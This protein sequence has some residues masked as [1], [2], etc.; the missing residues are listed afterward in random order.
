MEQLLKGE[1]IVVS[2]DE[3]IVFDQL[4][5]NEDAIFSLLVAGGYLKVEQVEYR[6]ILLVP[7]YHLKITNLE[8]MSMFFNMFQGW[9][10]GSKYVY[11]GFVK[12]LLK[13]DVKEMNAYM[14]E[15][16]LATFSSFDTGSHPSGRTQPERFYHGFVL[17]LLVELRERYEVRSNRESG[18]GR[19]DVM[20]VPHD[21]HERAVILEFK[22]FDK[23]EESS[24]KDTV[25]AA[26]RQI[27][28]KR[29]EEELLLQGI[30]K[31]QIYKYGF[32]FEGKKVLIGA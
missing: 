22:V 9:F 10:E 11:N 15:V 1:E 26:L 2:F 5:K 18:Y 17:G 19:Y 7:W 14:N 28:E 23:E 16:A 4:D 12:A 25:A 24:L 32:A 31:Q 13:G 29:Y 6:G 20:L 30:S 3:Q 27:E 8:T 21:K